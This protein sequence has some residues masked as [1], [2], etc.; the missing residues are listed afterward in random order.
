MARPIKNAD[1]TLNLMVWE[2]AIPGKKGVSDFSQRPTILPQVSTNQTPNASH[3]DTVGGRPVQAAHDLQGRLSDQS[4]QVQ[5]RAGP[6]PSERL[7]VW[8]GVPVAAGRGQGLASGHHHQADSARH[9]GPAQRT[10]HQG[11]GAG[12]GVHDLLPESL[13]IREAGA[14]PGPSDGHGIEWRRRSGGVV[15]FF[16]F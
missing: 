15:V 8:Y 9:P 14:R 13:G 10:E 2:C 4:A 12:G 16:F 11:S 1:G 7:S 6:V 5:I 3:I